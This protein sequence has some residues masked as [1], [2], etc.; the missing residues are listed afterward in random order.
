MRFGN[1]LVIHVGCYIYRVDVCCF[2]MAEE[3]KNKKIT[4]KPAKYMEKK[5][6][7]IGWYECRFNNT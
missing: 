1:Y 4:N 2:R 6:N 7:I 5:Y 3:K